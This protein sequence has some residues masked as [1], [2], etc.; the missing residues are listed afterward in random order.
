[1]FKSSF[2][3]W[4]HE[5]ETLIATFINAVIVIGVAIFVTS[6]V[7]NSQKRT[8][9]FLD[10]TKRYHGILGGAHKLNNEIATKHPA[11]AS[12]QPSRAEEG[13]A[14]QIYFQLFG[15]I[16]DEY[17]AY[18][19]RFLDQETI[20]DWLTWQMHDFNDQKF[21][22]GGVLYADAWKEWLTGPARD[23]SLTQVINKILECQNRECVTRVIKEGQKWWGWL[24]V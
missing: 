8:E 1:M 3:K 22:I 19:N 18:R 7:T 11:D 15:L 20:T 23:H 21:K 14:H 24:P 10:F 12:Y 17:Y 16:Y 9:F 6:A 13:D 4:L 2:T 5:W